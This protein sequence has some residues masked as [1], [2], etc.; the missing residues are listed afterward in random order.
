MNFIDDT[1]ELQKYVPISLDLGYELIRPDVDRAMVRYIKPLLGS[2]ILS[3]LKEA[4]ELSSIEEELIEYINRAAA[5]LAVWLYSKKGGVTIDSSGVY[6]PKNE[7]RWNLSEAEQKQLEQSYLADG[8]DA[9]DDLLNFLDENIAS[10]PTY[11]NSPERKAERHSLVPSAAIVQ[12]IF[13]LMHP[14]VT[15]H[16]MREGLRY[17]ERTRVKPILQ[18]YYETL[19][20]N[21]PTAGSFDETSLSL[22]RQA[23]IY[24]GTSRALLT[25][26]VKLTTEG[27]RVMMD[28]KAQV[29]E[30]ENSRIEAAAREYEKAGEEAISA[31]VKHLNSSPPEGY[32]K[33][34]TCNVT[35]PPPKF[36]T[37]SK[38]IFL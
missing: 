8:V 16:A 5:P 9:L 27:L 25:R 36:S 29:S 30:Y 3:E 26:G 32:S 7:N 14:R 4:A 23:V 20:A 22:A 13:H 28:N 1:T 38:I 35:L 33:P 31:L 15:F 37:N 10:F 12:D 18:A 34:D 2:A 6:K 11:A 17:A 19:V 21:T 24:L